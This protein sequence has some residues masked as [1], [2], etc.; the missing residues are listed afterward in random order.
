[1]P[2]SPQKFQP[3]SIPLLGVHSINASAGTGKTYTITTLY[4]RYLLEAGCNVEQILVTTFTKA[5]T[6][7]LKERI[8]KRLSDAMALMRYCDSLEAAQ[9]MVRSKLADAQLVALLDSIQAWDSDS[10]ERTC[11][12]LE[13]AIL[14][15]DQAPIFTIDSFCRQVLQL[16][17]FETGS[18]F[19]FEVLTSQDD[20]CE[21]A[22]RDFVAN[23]WGI[24]NSRIAD[25]LP[26]NES[27]W[28]L[29]IKVAKLAIDH[30]IYPIEPD[31]HG[32]EELLESTL[33]TQFKA[34]ANQ[35]VDVWQRDRGEIEQLLRKTQDQGCF[36]QRSYKPQQIDEALGFMDVFVGAP[37]FNAFEWDSKSGDVKPVQGRLAQSKL[38]A[39]ILK[40]KQSE[41]PQH[42]VFELIE[43]VIELAAKVREV[44]GNLKPL[45][46]A[47]VADFVRKKVSRHKHEHGL[48][49]FG[50][51]LHQVDNALS[52]ELRESLI[53]SLRDRF[54]V[55]LVD[56]FQDTDPIQFRI[57]ERV[58][59]DAA[60][61]SESQS[62]DNS[63][64][65][66]V[67]IG[68]PKQSIYKFRGADIHSY[69]AANERVPADHRHEMGTNWR[70]D[71]SL[72][73]AVQ[74]IFKSASNPFLTEKIGLPD[75]DAHY[76]DRLPDGP[77]LTINLVPRAPFVEPDKAPTNGVALQSVVQQVAS[78][79]VRQLNSAFQVP[80]GKGG[81]CDITPGAIAVLC[82]S[83]AQLRD[84]QQE[85]AQRLVPAVLYTDESVYE[86]SEAEFLGRVLA[87]LLKP[88]SL[89][90][91]ANAL[92]TP[93]FGLLANDLA[94]LPHDQSAI[95]DWAEKF[96]TWSSMWYRDG[97]I[98]MWRTLLDDVG[99]IRR[100]AQQTTGERQITN[101][102]HIG[103]LL[104]QQAVQSHAGPD[105]LHRWFEQMRFEPER[106]NDETQLRLETD[107]AAVQLVTIHKSKG[108]EYPVVYCPTLWSAFKPRTAPQYLLSSYDAG[109]VTRSI[110]VLDVGS[111]LFDD[112]LSWEKDEQAAED[113]RLLYVALTRARHQCHIYWTAAKSANESAAGAILLGALEGA[114]SD[115][116]IE[117]QLK[118]WAHRLGVARVQVRGAGFVRSLADPGSSRWS[119]ESPTALK[120]R[121]PK[122][123]HIVAQVQTSY[124]SLTRFADHSHVADDADRDAVTPDQSLIAIRPE[125]T[126]DLVPLAGMPGGTAVGDAVHRILET[127]LAG[128][129]FH[130]SDDG[131]LRS[132]LTTLFDVAQRRLALEVRWHAPF[133]ETL[134]ATLNQ[135]IS[136]LEPPAALLDIASNELACEMPFVLPLGSDAAAFHLESIGACFER[137]ERPIVRRYAERVRRLAA[138]ELQGFLTGFIDLVFEW[139]GRWYVLDYKT[140]NLGPLVSDYDSDSLDVSM[141]EHDYILQ[142]HLYCAAV[143]RFLK[144]RIPSFHFDRD[145]GG[146]LYLFLRGVE[147]GSQQLGGAYFDRPTAEVMESLQQVLSGRRL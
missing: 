114:E 28:S 123:E 120:H 38:A 31:G 141:F 47:Q 140:T 125:R 43:E 97:F 36:N 58:F 16:H 69:L 113:R 21:D 82:R 61:D 134:F 9:E 24:P 145:F 129:E 137:S 126:D 90:L 25:W 81:T 68:D 78:D 131:A 107:A 22:V 53:E 71:R 86:T 108:L 99:A 14:S 73:D 48:M 17:V 27:L 42:R 146:V 52:G 109:R 74:A 111:A 10:R 76:G 132:T 57:F 65:A 55:A 94:D 29:L 133:L 96:H 49:S 105:E 147:P 83:G 112:R 124:S 64:R 62:D 119:V 40:A 128:G 92:C 50:D 115:Q 12:R 46:L 143:E 139:N 93:L 98:V 45:L 144:Q 75:V 23:Y 39:G 110:P 34:K 87:V 60:A 116:V 136:Q 11:E 13:D 4:L 122:R 63:P 121:I 118:Q 35:L 32:W 8:R 7:E 88:G 66:F 33:V 135:Q 18:R 117:Q 142:Y 3:L 72:V 130:K 15:F 103:E 1:M 51:L 85:L 44:G 67:M 95:A 79:I 89:T 5:A 127:V 101:Y 84:V 41:T 20:L 6:A 30:P 54:R 102:L 100:L 91:M 19:Q 70:S 104:H 26:L 106:Q 138:K 80:D 59:L 2:A 37:S 56:E 77:A